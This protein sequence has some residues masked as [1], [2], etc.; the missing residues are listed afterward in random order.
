M[1][2]LF[3]CIVNL[4]NQEHREEGRSSYHQSG[5]RGVVVINVN[6]GDGVGQ[7]DRRERIR[8]GGVGHGQSVGENRGN[9]IGHSVDVASAR[10]STGSI[11][12]RSRSAGRSASTRGG[13]SS[14]RGTGRGTST[15]AGGTG[16]RGRSTGGG[17][18]GGRTRALSGLKRSVAEQF[19][20]LDGA[21]AEFGGSAFH[22][23][24]ALVL[25]SLT[26]A[27]ASVILSSV[28]GEATELIN[29]FI[30]G[31]SNLFAE[32]ALK[33]VSFLLAGAIHAG[34][35][36]LITVN[37]VGTASS[38]A[39]I[40]TN[41]ALL[42]A[43]TGASDG[44]SGRTTTVEISGVVGISLGSS[45]VGAREAILA[46]GGSSAS[47]AGGTGDGEAV[48]R[49][50]GEGTERRLHTSTSSIIITLNDTL[51]IIDLELSVDGGSRHGVGAFLEQGA[52]VVGLDIT[53]GD[54][55]AEEVVISVITKENTLDLTTTALVGTTEGAVA[56][57]EYTES[58]G[59]KNQNC[60]FHERVL[61]G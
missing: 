32:F 25:S 56:L 15:A 40:M 1:E 33:E 36:F 8:E 28:E 10:G 48:R 51:V 41:A 57:G 23:A 44:E 4:Q 19:S 34:I 2:F 21:R 52:A 9:I 54:I 50:H 42:E 24:V 13:R 35:E 53:L 22:S 30:V 11:G 20:L 49:G 18:R 58:T 27:D 46:G 17:D 60:D 45:T 31:A 5:S 59:Q 7:S 3:N 12:S 16:S 55:V 37:L 39:K 43:E 14:S 29:Q 6:R 26:R 47:F 61:K 38:V